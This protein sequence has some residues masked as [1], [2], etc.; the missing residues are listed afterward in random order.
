L[1]AGVAFLE[2]LAA[3]MKTGPVSATNGAN[4]QPVLQIPLPA[5]EVMRRGVTALQ[6][7]LQGLHPNE[8]ASE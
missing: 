8:P 7:I 1:Q 2:A 3:V 5:P 6:A 4:A